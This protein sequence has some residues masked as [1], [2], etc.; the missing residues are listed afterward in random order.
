MRKAAGWSLESSAAKLRDPN[1]KTASVLYR[2]AG[3]SD[4]IQPLTAHTP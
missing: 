4:I 3:D 1:V 2:C